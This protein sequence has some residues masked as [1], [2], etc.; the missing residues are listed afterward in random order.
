MFRVRAAGVDIFLCNVASMPAQGAGTKVAPVIAVHL[1]ERALANIPSGL[2]PFVLR[3]G[4]N[5]GVPL[6]RV[7]DVRLRTQLLRQVAGGTVIVLTSCAADSQ[8]TAAHATQ[9]AQQLDILREFRNLTGG[10]LA[11]DGRSYELLASASA[12]QNRAPREIRVIERDEAQRILARA[13]GSPWT[14]MVLRQLLEK[15]LPRLAQDSIPPAAAEGLVL[16]LRDAQIRART[17]ESTPSSEPAARRS[18]SEQ[19]HWVE[20][21]FKDSGTRPLAGAQYRITLPD[22]SDIKDQLN[23]QGTV[24]YEEQPSGSASIQILDIE[25]ANWSEDEIDAHEPVELS[26]EVSDGYPAGESV[27]FDIFRLYRERDA[28]VVASLRGRL[29]SDG[30]VA[31]RWTP[32]SIASPDDQFVFKASI[33]KV[34]RKSAPLAVRHRAIS[35]EWSSAQAQEGDTLTL[36]AILRGIPDGENATLKIFEKQ[37]RGGRNTLIDTRSATVKGGVVESI[38]TVPAAAAPSPRGDPGRRDFNYTVQAANL[39]HTSR[40]VAVFPAHNSDGTDGST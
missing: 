23:S 34:W 6:C 31:T 15:V 25:A 16:V 37:W 19:K 28:E 30:H 24:R 3:A 29:D 22:A 17:R 9:D 14:G 32:S 40:H 27:K 7:S 4:L 1:L 20:F 35:A 33:R 38:W 21:R 18:A 12:S 13:L 10:V 8:Q 26:V 5:D 11:V 2:R 36:R 39:Q